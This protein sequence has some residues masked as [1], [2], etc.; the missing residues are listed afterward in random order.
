MSR[1]IKNDGVTLPFLV[2]FWSSSIFIP[3]NLGLLLYELCICPAWPHIFHQRYDLESWKLFLLGWQRGR[4]TITLPLHP[5]PVSFSLCQC[6]CLCSLY[7][8]SLLAIFVVDVF[9]VVV[10]S[11][12]ITF[13]HNEANKL[14]TKRIYILPTL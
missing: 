13:L 8:Y 12:C 3:I 14:V 4:V 10:M 1:T 2:H 5:P 7:L 6:L 11:I 9:V